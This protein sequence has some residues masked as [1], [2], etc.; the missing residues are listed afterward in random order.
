MLQSIH[1]R[2][3]TRLTLAFGTFVV[4]VVS[5]LVG[6]GAQTFAGWFA[7]IIRRFVWSLDRNLAGA[8]CRWD[9]ATDLGGGMQGRG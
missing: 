9:V 2:L 3:L 1:L 6:P 5:T 8:R 7:T 4:V